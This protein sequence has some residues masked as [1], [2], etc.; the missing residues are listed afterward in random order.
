M[1]TLTELLADLDAEYDDLRSVVEDLAEDAPEW[2][3]ITPAEGWAVRDQIS[4]LAFFDEAGRMAMVDPEA[5]ARLVDEVVAGVGDPMDV[6]LVQGRAM[7]GD[8]LLEW[9]GTAHRGMVEVF[10]VADP[11][12]R[13]P[14]FGPPMGALSF[15]SARLMETWAHGQDVCDALG[16]DR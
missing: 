4:H 15:I 3:L 14:W 16:A 2:D 10:T 7:G 11:K 13:V 1:V 9:W 8:E 6:H 5:F 12:S